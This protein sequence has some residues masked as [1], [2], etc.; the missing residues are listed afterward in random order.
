MLSLFTF[1]LDIPAIYHDIK[2]RRGSAERDCHAG[3]VRAMP[4]AVN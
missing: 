2:N 1:P 3:W 4:P